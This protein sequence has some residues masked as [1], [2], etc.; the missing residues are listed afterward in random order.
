MTVLRPNNPGSRGL[1][2]LTAEGEAELVRGCITK[3]KTA[4]EII[5]SLGLPNTNPGPAQPKFSDVEIVE[6][7]REVKGAVTAFMRRNGISHAEM[8]EELY[9]K[10]TFARDVER[11]CVDMDMGN[12]IWG[13]KRNHLLVAGTKPCYPRELSW[14]VEGD[15]RAIRIYLRCWM[16][17]RA[18]RS[19][20]D[21]E[22]KSKKKIHPP[23]NGDKPKTPTSRKSFEFS[24]IESSEE[25]GE[26]IE[27]V[28]S[29]LKATTAATASL[30]V[31]AT[32]AAAV[33]AAPTTMRARLAEGLLRSV[34]AV[35]APVARMYSTPPASQVLLPPILIPN[36]RVESPLFEPETSVAA[37][38][39]R[40][41]RAGSN[42]DLY[43]DPPRP[44]QPSSLDAPISP[45]GFNKRKRIDN[46]QSSQEPPPTQGK[47]PKV[48]QSWKRALPEN[49]K[50]RR[51][52][53]YV[54]PQSPSHSAFTAGGEPWPVRF[55]RRPRVG[56]AESDPSYIPSR[57]SSVETE[58]EDI[59]QMISEQLD[60]L[61][62][63]SQIAETASPTVAV[64]ATPNVPE[65]EVEDTIMRDS[66]IPGDDPPRDDTKVDVFT[67]VEQEETTEDEDEDED[68]PLFPTTANESR[69]RS[70]TISFHAPTTVTSAAVTTNIA[71]DIATNTATNIATIPPRAAS[72]A[73]IRSSPEP[74]ISS[75]QDTEL[76]R[77]LFI[78]LLSFLNSLNQFTADSTSY[79]R[80][81]DRLNH[82]LYRFVDSDM[83]NLLLTHPDTFPTL[84]TAFGTWMSMRS[85][86]RTFQNKIQYFGA[87]GE[88]WKAWLR[89]RADAGERARACIALAEMHDVGAD[90]GEYKG[91]EGRERL[92]EE[93]AV[94]FD[95]L[96]KFKGCNGA[97]E[98]EGIRGYNE[99]LWV[100]FMSEE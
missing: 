29:P 22:R 74:P 99:R 44:G 54:V 37:E 46:S 21:Q 63:S 16:I 42:D 4:S 77:E 17:K 33:T 30:T 59:D 38:T 11:I 25:E 10:E 70:A 76:R 8:K 36:S 62:R 79:L 28:R 26:I 32:T 19:I 100:W 15:Q 43:E 14:E 56:S 49:P 71:T 35:P 7:N 66:V 95:V 84:H 89:G 67:T 13:K 52:D 40:K 47:L 58:E 39:P 94:L 93:L 64:P 48:N 80:T 24:E 6:L 91:D 78:L 86:L 9:D 45:P 81:E 68:A 18:A 20:G 41:E 88:S 90:C 69:H 53:T 65:Q 97:E 98:F 75:K 27:Y 92:N 50:G 60:S 34:A 72:A 51:Q 57:A 85:K 31:A 73:P 12:R 23:S 61:F 83:S 82:L 96:T 1:P 3:K 5:E 87:P 2:P 55:G